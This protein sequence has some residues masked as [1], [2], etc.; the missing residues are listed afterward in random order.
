VELWIY[1]VHVHVLVGE[2]VSML[3]D[4]P[5]DKQ[6]SGTAPLF[7]RL[8]NAICEAAL[9]HQLLAYTTTFS[10]LEV[11][12]QPIMEGGHPNKKRRKEKA[13]AMA[14]S[15]NPDAPP[16][17]ASAYRWND[18]NVFHAINEDR[19]PSDKLFD[20]PHYFAIL[21][22]L[23]VTAGHALMITKHKAATMLDIMPPEAAADTMG[24][25]QVR[26]RNRYCCCASAA[27]TTSNSS[28][29]HREQQ[30]SYENFLPF[31]YYISVECLHQHIQTVACC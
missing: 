5:C 17:S 22:K 4:Q 16:V 12:R 11:L 19:M 1:A 30:Q 13:S 28:N 6:Y 18:R 20:R 27:A 15:S 31:P 23:P 29:K 25:L 3:P 26:H 9:Q 8:H 10:L 7:S 24:D 21:D 2:A 14:E